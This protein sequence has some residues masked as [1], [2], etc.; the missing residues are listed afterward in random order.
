MP[1]ARDAPDNPRNTMNK[2]MLASFT[3]ILAGA[4]TLPAIADDT[5]RRAGGESSW[6]GGSTG[7]H[8][9]DGDRSPG[10]GEHARPAP[11]T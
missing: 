6:Q 5:V 7:P 3:A 1:W 9:V 11:R 2:L 10:N 8:R 4:M